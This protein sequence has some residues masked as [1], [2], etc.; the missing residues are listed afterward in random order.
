MIHKDSLL[1]FKDYFNDNIGQ[2]VSIKADVG[3]NKYL[4]KSG[5][6]EG[7]YSNYFL[8]KDDKLNCNVC[9]NYSDLSNK[10]EVTFNDDG[11]IVGSISDKSI[12]KY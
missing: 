9:Y 7:V 2:E 6:I 8:I 10:L 5:T 11:R 4:E 12:P 1:Q 3:R